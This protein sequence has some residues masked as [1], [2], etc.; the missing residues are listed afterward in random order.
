MGKRT[1]GIA[2]LD[3]EL[4]ARGVLPWPWGPKEKR[5]A[6]TTKAIGQL[7]DPLV[8][9]GLAHAVTTAFLAALIPAPGHQAAT[10]LRSVVPDRTPCPDFLLTGSDGQVRFVVEVKRGASAQVTGLASFPYDDFGARFTDQRSRSLTRDLGTAEWHAVQVDSLCCWVHTGT[11]RGENQGGLYQ[12]DVYRHWASW[13]PA[14][15]ALPDPAKVRWILLDEEGRTPEQAFPDAFSTDLWEPGN[16]ADFAW[17]LL[18]VY[19]K[20]TPGEERDRLEKTLRMLAS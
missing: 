3:Q 11:R 15:C 8:F 20:L 12:I 1:H 6:Q 7:F 14:G 4:A 9:P 13:V 17:R 18:E 19:D 16:L 10:A 2:G 5:E